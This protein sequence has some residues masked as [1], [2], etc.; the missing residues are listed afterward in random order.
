MKPVTI[1]HV[2][3]SSFSSKIL[4][5]SAIRRIMELSN[6][7]P[8]PEGSIETLSR[9]ESTKNK[10]ANIINHQFNL[11]IYLKQRELTTIRQEIAKAENILHDL[12]L[13]VENET[14]AANMP[15]AAHYTRRSAMYYHGGSKALLN[16][17]NTSTLPKRKV[18][19]TSEKS[20]LY[21]R[22]QDG[23]YVSLAC[24]ACHRD[25][26]ANQQG[27][28]N[29]CRISHNLE[30]GPYEQIMLKCG[31]PVDESEVPLDSP[32]RT[33]PVMNLVPAVRYEY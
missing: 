4:E 5:I 11:E 10:I 14:M 25:D 20:K 2:K 29:H 19:R 30:F 33:R 1:F 3:Y 24:P 7:D 31:T 22:R 27:F 16:Q 6:V 28:L 26:F 17:G 32:A 18:Y 12:K 8:P 21:G 9:D 15:E 23:I 13:A